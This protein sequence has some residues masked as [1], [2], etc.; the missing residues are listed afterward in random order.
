MLKNYHFCLCCVVT[1]NTVELR[2]PYFSAR[3]KVGLAPAGLAGRLMRRIRVLVP[4]SAAKLKLGSD[5]SFAAT[6]NRLA[7]GPF[8]T[9][10]STTHCVNSYT[11]HCSDIF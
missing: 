6:K 5:F 2:P 10:R 3:A 7:P 4:A 1:V 11:L 8:Q 9:P